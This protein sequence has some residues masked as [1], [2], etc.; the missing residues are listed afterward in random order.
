MRVFRVTTAGENRL[1]RQLPFLPGGHLPRLGGDPL[2]TRLNA[3]MKKSLIVLVSALAL[4]AV[5]FVSTTSAQEKKGRGLMSPEQR[6]AQIEENVGA[7]TAEQKSKITAILEKAQKDARAM[8]KEERKEKGREVLQA[9]AKE[10]RAVLTPEQQA[11]YDAASS[12]GG[13]RAK[14]KE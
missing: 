11:K 1:G 13:R 10:I 6:I 5:A 9:T 2:Q 12:A 7:L 3:L 14:K 4:S 8:P